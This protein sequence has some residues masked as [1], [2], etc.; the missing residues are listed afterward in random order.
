MLAV[1][2]PFFDWLCHPCR[3]HLRADR[4]RGS[5]RRSREEG[6]FRGDF[7]AHHRGGNRQR[8]VRD[9]A[10]VTITYVKV[11]LLDGREVADMIVNIYDV[12][13]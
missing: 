5:G 7:G 4:L 3:R 12:R 13:E 9:T 8:M 2:Q 1:R 10:D 11:A 6:D